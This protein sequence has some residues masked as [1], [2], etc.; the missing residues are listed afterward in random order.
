MAEDTRGSL[1]SGPVFIAN[2]RLLRRGI[3]Y[4]QRRPPSRVIAYS[5]RRLYMPRDCAQ[6]PFSA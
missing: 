1:F 5:Q 4:M 2:L 3:A 6:P